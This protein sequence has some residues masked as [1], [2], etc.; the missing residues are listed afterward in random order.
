MIPPN[1][2]S[3]CVGMLVIMLIFCCGAVDERGLSWLEGCLHAWHTE[4]SSTVPGSGI[5][6]TAKKGAGA[7]DHA[8]LPTKIALQQQQQQRVSLL[9]LWQ[10]ECIAQQQRPPASL[11][12][13][14]G[15]IKKQLLSRKPQ[16]HSAGNV[17]H[18]RGCCFLLRWRVAG[19]YG[20]VTS[21]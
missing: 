12:R 6:F 17:P 19:V 16:Q 11:Y 15:P 21:W 3:A 20:V 5:L 13:S 7:L 14:Q 9:C 1:V 8:R 2:V 4:H 10:H 18:T